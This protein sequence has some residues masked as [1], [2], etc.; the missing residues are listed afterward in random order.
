MQIP[1]WRPTL[2]SQR[3][4]GTGVGVAAQGGEAGECRLALHGQ[5]SDGRVL[6][7]TEETEGNEGDRAIVPAMHTN[8]K[9]LKLFY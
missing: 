5:V 2:V 4:Q 7:Y 6:T 9:I 3:H 1:P 8:P